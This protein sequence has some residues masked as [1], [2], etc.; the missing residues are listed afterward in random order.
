M[1]VL[2][3][4]GAGFIGTNLC[5]KLL[6]LGHEVISLDRVPSKFGYSLIHDVN[7][8]LPNLEVDEI[9]NLASNPSPAHYI[10]IP[11]NTSK[12][13]ILGVFNV[14]DLAREND[15]KI[16]QAS[17]CEVFENIEPDSNRACYRL[18]KKMAESIFF[19]YLRQYK[20]EIRIA[21]LY[22]TYGPH[23]RLDD[24]R[25]IPEFIRRA[26]NNEDIIIF[27]NAK[28]SFCYIDDVV[29]ALIS[30][31]ESRWLDVNIGSLEVFSVLEIADMIVEVTNSKSDITVID[32]RD[33]DFKQEV[34]TENLAQDL[35]G[36]KPK[37]SFKEGIT[38]TIEYFMGGNIICGRRN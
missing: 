37:V 23:I 2:V 18:G 6:D 30:L 16:L 17:T 15:A 21:R 5:K 32:S 10:N 13:N 14:L 35:L 29:D 26:L 12:T 19:D 24:G 28:R 4:G 36:W 27:G 31:M 8:K 22:N 33:D 20:T 25:V 7:D 38:K 11:V 1:R 9:Y 3:T 34:R